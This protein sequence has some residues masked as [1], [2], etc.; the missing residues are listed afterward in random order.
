MHRPLESPA[1]PGGSQ[2]S[3]ARRGSPF[4]LLKLLQSVNVHRLGG[5]NPLQPGVLCLQS[6][7]LS[8]LALGHPAKAV[9]PSVDGL[10]A[11]S[12]VSG[13]RSRVSCALYFQMDLDDLFLVATFSA[14]PGQRIIPCFCLFLGL[15]RRKKLSLRSGQFMGREPVFVRNS[16]SILA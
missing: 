6:L 11:D 5:H 2:P 8:Q 10:N 13:D 3:C 1:P 12:L 7:Q 16:A 4:S 9:A 14:C 15:G